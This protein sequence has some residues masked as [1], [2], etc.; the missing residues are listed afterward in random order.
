LDT[1]EKIIP[2]LFRTE[3]SKLVAVLCKFYGLNSIEFAEDIVSDTF[4]KASET[5]GLKGIPQNPTA[6]LYTVAKNKIKDNFK[7][8]HLYNQKIAPELKH[9]Q[10]KFD[11]IE[12]DFSEQNIFDSQL[13]MLFAI[14]TPLLSKEAQIPFALR[15]LCGFGIVEIASALLTTKSTINK[16]LVRAK[17]TL[18][19]HNID[20]SMPNSDELSER[21]DNVLSILYLLFNEGY[22][23][24]TSKTLLKKDICINAMSLLNMLLNYKLTNLS[25]S[26][27]LMALFCFQ[28]SR[29]DARQNPDGELI[30]Y[31]DQDKS[32]WNLELI[33]KGNH[34]LVLSANQ[35]NY[36]KYSLE[37]LIA[38]WHS[39][40][41]VDEQVKWE[42]ILQL[43]NQ[44]IQIE[45][46]PITAMNRTYAL[47]KVNGSELAIKEALKINLTH[48]Y[49]YHVLLAELY[50]NNLVKRK[51]HLNL[52][53]N[54]AKTESE[55]MFILNKTNEL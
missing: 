49:F 18:K 19:A 52:A 43:Y 41:N 33:E 20:L 14:C 44:L 32:K 10:P 46:S 24:S 28:S 50:D 6:W 48:N 51:E 47:G 3:Y 55:K 36:T 25:D 42:A 30:L 15:V 35:T 1:A 23:S 7:R 53:L 8:T 5:W 12:I 13:E 21:L 39:K 4:L 38:Y 29:F 16:R 17:S 40:I 37:A 27:A 9:S 11:S 22:Y 2:H 26:N 34:F 54:L 45:Y 31:N